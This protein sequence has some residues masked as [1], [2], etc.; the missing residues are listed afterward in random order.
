MKIRP[1][2]PVRYNMNKEKPRKYAYTCVHCRTGMVNRLPARCP[3]CDRWL[4]EEIIRKAK[5]RE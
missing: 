5:S 4:S 2:V 3:E 1:I